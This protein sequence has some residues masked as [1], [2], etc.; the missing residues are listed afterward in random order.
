MDTQ[1]LQTIIDYNL[2]EYESNAFKLALIWEDLTKKMFPKEKALSKLP[3]HGDP[4][5]STLFKYCWKLI[6]ETRGLL[7]PEEYK[8]YIKAN[9]TIIK[10]NNLHLSPNVLCGDSAWI[11][12]R[13][14]KKLYD[15]KLLEKTGEQPKLNVEVDPKIVKKME[16][17]KRFLFEKCEGEP[18]KDKL[19][20]FLDNKSLHLWAG[21]RISYFYLLLSPWIKS[22]VPIKL[23]EKELQFDS[24]LYECQINDNLRTYFK[25]EFD[26]EF[27]SP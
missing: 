13:I 11:R 9:L 14:W 17:T 22:I 12:W 1:R 5:K 24:K 19:Q 2:T 18:T 26:Y 15:Q 23:L 6:R 10:C 3:K 20:A 4:R 21:D 8:L 7:K 25:Q 27:L 16:L